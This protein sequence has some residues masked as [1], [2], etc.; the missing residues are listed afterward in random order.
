MS[1]RA[2]YLLSFSAISRFDYRRSGT[3]P[4]TGVWQY[5]VGGSGFVSF[6][7]NAYSSTS[8]SGASLGAINLA[9]LAALQNIGP[10]TNV[11]FR[12][13]NY[14]ASDAGGT[15]YLYDVAG[16]TAA[17][18]AI[19]GTLTALAGPPAAAPLLSL[20]GQADGQLQF[21]LTGTAGSNYIVETAATL[22]PAAWTPV[23][24]GAAP[25][26]FHTP[27]TNPQSFYRGKAGP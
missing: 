22:P 15:W 8:S 2:G 3:G 25:F 24:S 11:T 18:L 13:V 14:G 6:A 9:N 17:D 1:A 7:T 27:A 12:L 23:H 16:S 26:L 21:T 5:Q 4:G 10:G 19:Q 20:V